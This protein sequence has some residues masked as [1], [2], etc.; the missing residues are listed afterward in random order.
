MLQL[1]NTRSGHPTLVRG[2]TF[3]HSTY[4]P[5]K[6]A[7]RFISESCKNET[8]SC[9]VLL[10]PGLGYL[11]RAIR[12][13]FPISRQICIYYS[14]KIFHLSQVNNTPCWHPG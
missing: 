6:E 1:A 2:K 13:Q 5:I 3:I 8:P 10:G 9:I 11:R 12:E 4:D 7:N 14:E